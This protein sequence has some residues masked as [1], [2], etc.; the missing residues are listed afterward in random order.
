VPFWRDLAREERAS[1]KEINTAKKAVMK[2][3]NADNQN[4][5]EISHSAKTTLYFAKVIL[6][7]VLSS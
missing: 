4:E 7:D 3:K 2:K 1:E 6:C 5:F